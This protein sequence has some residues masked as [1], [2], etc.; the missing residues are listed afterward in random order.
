[1]AL[2]MLLVKS[3]DSSVG[4]ATRLGAWRQNDRGS[5]PGGGW[6]FFS[7][8]QGPDRLW[9]SPNLCHGTHVTGAFSSGVKWQER[10]ADHFTSI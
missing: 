1:M 2:Y 3:R 10:E 5:I 4:V 8:T 7:S 6:E 9:G